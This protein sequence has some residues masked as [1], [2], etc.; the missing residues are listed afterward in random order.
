VAQASADSFDGD[1][2][3]DEFGGVGVAEL[4]DV[5][6]NAGGFAVVLPAMVG[7]VVGE[8]RRSR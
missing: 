2:S 3:V 6:L 8:G 7:A 1:A 4:V 5:D